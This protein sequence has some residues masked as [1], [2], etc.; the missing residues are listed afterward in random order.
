M[1]DQ[2]EEMIKTLKRKSDFQW[3][4]IEGIDGSLNV[5]KQIREEKDKKNLQMEEDVLKTVST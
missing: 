5:L 3:Q 1:N 4:M 2:I